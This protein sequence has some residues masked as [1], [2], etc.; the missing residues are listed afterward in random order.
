MP[1]R[2]ADSKDLRACIQQYHRLIAVA[3]IH[4]GIPCVDLNEIEAQRRD[5]KVAEWH[6]VEHH[7]QLRN[8]S[9]VTI[10]RDTPCVDLPS[11]TCDLVA[12]SLPRLQ[13]PLVHAGKVE[14]IFHRAMFLD[15]ADRG[16]ESTPVTDTRR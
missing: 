4:I 14:S 11:E 13:H 7:G 12:A 16:E 3:C 5:L 6:A 9:L 2:L 15:R 1:H 8:K 10:E